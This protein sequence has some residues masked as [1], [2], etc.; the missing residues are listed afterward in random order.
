NVTVVTAS[1]AVK[2]GCS[3]VRNGDGTVT[4]NY[5]GRV[6]NT[7]RAALS[8]VTVQDNKGG[9]PIA[10]GTLAGGATHG[11]T[12]SYTLLAS[13]PCDTDVSDMVT[14]TGTVADSTLCAAVANRTVSDTKSATCRTPACAPKIQVIKEV[15]CALP[16]GDCTAFPAVAA[17]DSAAHS[18]SGVTINGVC[19]KFCY[20]ITIRNTGTVPLQSVVVSDDSVPDPNLNL[21]SCNAT[22]PAPLA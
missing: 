14:A 8:G 7:G 21:A 13:T 9:S 17:K 6:T 3:T 10:I 15:V 11:Y 5:R 1:I 2:R 19:P 22:M 16:N 20:R 12:G 4:V 18:A